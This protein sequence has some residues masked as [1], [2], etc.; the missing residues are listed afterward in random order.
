M[1]IFKE[2]A[3]K[4]DGYY[5]EEG[6]KLI[7]GPEGKLFFDA[8]ETI[9]DVNGSLITIYSTGARGAVRTADPIRII[10]FLKKDSRTELTIFP[11]SKLKKLVEFFIPGKSLKIPRKIRSQF[12]FDGNQKLIN[13][14]TSDRLFIENILNEEVYIVINKKTSQ[15]I[16]LTPAY[17]VSSLE[18]FDKFVEILKSIETKIEAIATTNDRV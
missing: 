6:E 11:K 18:Q 8:K 15:N 1:N 12:S 5:N 3:S 14:L 13:E 7:S 10:L 9:I 4:H 17:G 16:L 2:I